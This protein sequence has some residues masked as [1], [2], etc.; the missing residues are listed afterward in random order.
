MINVL[1]VVFRVTSVGAFISW[2]QNIPCSN[3]E[4]FRTVGGLKDT[5][6]LYMGQSM[7]ILKSGA[8]VSINLMA[9]YLGKL[10]DNSEGMVVSKLESA[11]N[12]VRNACNS[13]RGATCFPLVYPQLLLSP[14][15]AM[16]DAR[17]RLRY[18]QRFYQGPIRNHIIE[19]VRI[20]RCM[21]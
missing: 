1:Q 17:D 18:L 6:N 20:T 10:E 15:Y 4:S 19:A 7:N 5:I 8:W 2:L 11:N 16:K 13:H 12:M 21:L 3:G 9:N 14:L